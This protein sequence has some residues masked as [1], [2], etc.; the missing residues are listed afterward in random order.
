MPIKF[1]R[2]HILTKNIA[3]IDGQSG[4]GKSLIGPIISSLS[5]SEHWLH[6]HVIEE[7]I[8]LLLFKKIQI[9]AARSILGVQADLDLYNLFIGRDVNFRDKDTSSVNYSGLKSIYSKRLKIKDGDNITKKIKTK[10]PFL[11]INTH[12]LLMNSNLIKRA[13]LNRN[14][15]FISI[16]RNPITIIN[17]FHEGNWEKKYYKNPREF[18]LTVSS[19]S[20]DLDVWY[21]DKYNGKKL[22][23]IEKYANFVLDYHKYQHKLKNKNHLLIN[24]EKFIINPNEYIKLLEKKFGKKTKITKKLLKTFNLPRKKI[25]I[26][27]E[28]D[29]EKVYNLIKDVN[30][31]N[32]LHKISKDFNNN[33]Y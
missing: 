22:S 14:L 28:R 25:D 20:K 29:E 5:N 31:K 3:L 21:L 4:S 17:K 27:L 11:L 7:T 23:F 33:I 13:F 19:N 30:T 1:T 9:D 24:Y 12:H 16:S 2:K 32:K 8:I 18:T 26:N 15:F 10:N 6:D